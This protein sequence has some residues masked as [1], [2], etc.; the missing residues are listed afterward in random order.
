MAGNFW[1]PNQRD[2]Q[3][4]SKEQ[5]KKAASIEAEMA[6][7]D[8]EPR[9]DHD[10]YWFPVDLAHDTELVCVECRSNKAEKMYT[11][12]ENSRNC[13]NCSANDQCQYGVAHDQGQYTRVAPELTEQ[14]AL[15][16]LATGIRCALE[17]SGM[18]IIR[19]DEDFKDWLVNVAA[20]F[21]ANMSL[22]Y[23]EKLM[24]AV[25]HMGGVRVP[26]HQVREIFK[27]KRG[28]KSL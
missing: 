18:S 13:I 27:N 9:A 23:G 6:P 20:S 5:K 26:S 17:V 10:I 14:Q 3:P 24:K 28:K 25:S 7:T 2:Q 21:V 15:I 12:K 11:F 1:P 19:I 22:A 4:I 8:L 16:I